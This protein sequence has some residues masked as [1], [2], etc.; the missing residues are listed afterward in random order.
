VVRQASLYFD[1]QSS[2]P[3]KPTITTAI[4]AFG[5]RATNTYVL[6]VLRR[7]AETVQADEVADS[8]ATRASASTVDDSLNLTKG[9]IQGRIRSASLFENELQTFAV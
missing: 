5:A 8:A 4:S 6:A 9:G 2:E 3:V 1:R 7:I